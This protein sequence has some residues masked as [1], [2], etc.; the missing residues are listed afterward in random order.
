[1]YHGRAQQLGT[2]RAGVTAVPA[3]HVVQ[4]G[5]RPLAGWSRRNGTT[6]ARRDLVARHG[7]LGG[8]SAA[9]GSAF[10]PGAGSRWSRRLG[11]RGRARPGR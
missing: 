4:D 5:H 11:R 8:V 3:Q 10:W 2:S 6:K 7:P 1:M 9:R